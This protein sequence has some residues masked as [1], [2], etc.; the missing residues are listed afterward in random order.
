MSIK[1]ARYDLTEFRN[2]TRGD[3][4]SE[5]GR[6]PPLQVFSKYYI[7]IA[8]TTEYSRST[9]SHTVQFYELHIT[10]LSF[11]ISRSS[12]SIVSGFLLKCS[13]PRSNNW[14]DV[15]PDSTSLSCKLHLDHLTFPQTDTWYCKTTLCLKLLFSIKLAQQWWNSSA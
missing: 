9:V 15:A 2:P 10:R 14:Y 8:T 1:N 13:V 7:N 5:P 6:R 4:I 11:I 3:R 12:L